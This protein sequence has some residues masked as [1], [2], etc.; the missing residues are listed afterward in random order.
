M[1]LNAAKV[2]ILE[3]DASLSQ[4]L[5]EAFKRAGHHVLLATRADEAISKLRENKIDHLFVDCLL[6]GTTGPDFVAKLES[7]FPTQKFR[8]IMMSG[9]FTDKSFINETTKR[10]RAV[11]FLQKPF[12]LADAVSFIK[13]QNE[14]AST[15][16][17]QSNRKKLYGMFSDAKVSARKKR[18]V[19]EE[20]DEIS[21]YDLPFIYSLLVETNSSGT[22]FIYY[23]NKSV[24]SITFCNGHIVNVDVEDKT[25]YFGEMLIQSGYST[26]E[27]VQAALNQKRERRIG[28][29]LI[30]SNQLS[31]H[32][33][34]LILEEQMNLR[35]AKTINSEKL[36]VNFATSDTEMAF[37]NID[38]E[39]L[40]SFSHDWIASKIPTAWL[41][42]LFVSWS[43]NQ[44]ALGTAYGDD[45]PALQTTL[46]KSCEGIVARIKS[47]TSL[48][49][50]IE[51]KLYSEDSLYKTVL[52]LLTRG[53]IYFAEKTNSLSEKEQL[54]ALQNIKNQIH[55]KT[56]FEIYQYVEATTM[57]TG[58]LNDIM[59]EFVNLIGNQPADLS[60]EVGVLWA[61][62]YQKVNDSLTVAMDSK[63]R[64]S[65]QAA[66][67]K[68]AAERKLKAN[69]YF[70]E[71][72][73]HLHTN[74]HKKALDAIQEAFNIEPEGYQVRLYL[75]WAK[76]VNIV[77][78]KK[79][80]QLKEIELELTQIPPDEKYDAVFPFVLGLFAKIKGD[81]NSAKRSFQKSLAIDA[82]YL[83]AKREM[84][85]IEAST[86]KQDIMK[87]DLKDVVSGFF[88]R[89]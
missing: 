12:D 6:P 30:Q 29:Y 55:E 85:L 43:G 64:E 33:F 75:A 74:S 13:V 52:F 88:K 25:T 8:V 18:K 81:L 35:L 42:S 2:L 89:K 10:T 49:K 68:A 73:K 14:T 26:P 82:T 5:S 71:A 21:G 48:G 22:L 51:A 76:L 38:S 67:A 70:E 79:V 7:E 53:L 39:A 34:D 44:I 24:S 17:A 87:M 62:V 56:A 66:S 86:K 47:G 72:K 45:H 9:I 69:A 36:K 54:A 57:M 31:P 84:N 37:P 32:A 3:D 83:P 61:E 40:M 4:G 77:E 27:D 19:I 46:V 16:R 41:K 50:L 60:S 80:A 1:S 78:A 65:M 28:Q 11:G 23:P 15:Q 59:R 20:M 58:E 63:M